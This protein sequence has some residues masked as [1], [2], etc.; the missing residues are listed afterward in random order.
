MFGPTPQKM[1][2]LCYVM[3]VT[4]HKADTGNEEEEDVL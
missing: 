1:K 2:G 3:P 4:G